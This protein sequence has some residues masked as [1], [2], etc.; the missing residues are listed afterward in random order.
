MKTIQTLTRFFTLGVVLSLAVMACQTKDTTPANDVTLET[1]A[2]LGKILAGADGKT[3][4]FFAA[5]V[6]GQ[7]ACTSAQCVANWPVFY[8]D[9]TK[10]LLGT[11]LVSTDFATITRSDGKMQTTYKGWPLYYFANDT[12]SGDVLGENVGGV[13]YAAKPN[14]SLYLAAGQLVGNDGKNYTTPNSVSYV[15]GQGS[16]IYL[17]DAVGRTLYGFAS[18]KNNKNNYTRSDFSNNPTWPLLEVTATAL[19]DLPSALKK[20]DFSSITVFGRDQLTYKG[21][22]LY[23]FGLDNATRGITKGVSVPRPGVWPIVNATT[24]VAPN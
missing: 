13:W 6:T 14:Y 19:Q 15:E 1:N 9:N 21:W 10:M 12:K 20:S 17:T 8:K 5:D 18:D 4:Y 11:G 3:L 2:T 7:S 22:P 16:T 23:Y 24:P